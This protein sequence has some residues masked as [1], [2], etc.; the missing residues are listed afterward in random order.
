LGKDL[1]LAADPERKGGKGNKKPEASGV[2][3]GRVS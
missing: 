1:M 2:T 3:S